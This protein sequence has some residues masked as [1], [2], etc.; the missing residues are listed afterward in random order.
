[1]KHTTVNTRKWP[2]V[3]NVDFLTSKYF[4]VIFM[5]TSVRNDSFWHNCKDSAKRNEIE[6]KSIFDFRFWE[7][8]S[9]PRETENK[10]YTIQLTALILDCMFCWKS[11][12][13][14]QITFKICTSVVRADQPRECDNWRLRLFKHMLPSMLYARWR[15]ANL[16]TSTIGHGK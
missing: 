3:N 9:R 16:S 12:N 7:I 5:Q 1:M 6:M 10:T 2:E 8:I 14:P 13:M 4:R 15:S 11:L